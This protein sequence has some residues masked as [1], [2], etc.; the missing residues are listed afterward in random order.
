[1][2]QKFLDEGLQ[3]LKEKEFKEVY[4]REKPAD[5]IHEC[6]LDTDLDALIPDD[7]VEN[8]AER[9]SLYKE[10]SKITEEEKLQMFLISLKDR[11]GPLPVEVDNLSKSMRIKWLGKLLGFEMVR[12]KG[13]YM[14]AYFISKQESEFFSS[15]YFGMLLQQIQLNSDCSIR[16]KN[17]KLSL[18]FKN[19]KSIDKAWQILSE[20]KNSLSL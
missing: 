10:L 13:G 20:L 6:Q 15:S 2:Y 12:L 17:N 8:V 18:I 4:K 5:F 1:M 16:E 11:F 7:Y 14:Y 19:V 9:L 3:E